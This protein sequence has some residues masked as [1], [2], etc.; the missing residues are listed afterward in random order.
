MKPKVDVANASIRGKVRSYSFDVE[1]WRHVQINNINF[2]A[3]PIQCEKCEH[4][5][6]ENV[7]FDFA[8]V[9]RR[10]L[11]EA[12]TKA[13]M[14]RLSTGRKGSGHFTL[15]NCRISDTDSQALVVQGAW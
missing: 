8:G 10:M 4:I 14:L 1:G 6:L 7:N 3:A 11:G 15:R 2:Y 12:G 5:I 13:E 9:S